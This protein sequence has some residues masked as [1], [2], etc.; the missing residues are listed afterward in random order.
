MPSHQRTTRAAQL[1]AARKGA[2]HCA[3]PGAAKGQHE[4]AAAVAVACPVGLHAQPPCARLTTA[5]A[6]WQ[7]AR[8]SPRPRDRRGNPPGRR[9]AFAPQRAPTSESR[10][11][12]KQQAWAARPASTPVP[13]GMAT[14]R[15]AALAAELTS[16]GASAWRAFFAK[17]R[18]TPGPPWVLEAWEQA[19]AAAAATLSVGDNMAA[20]V[21]LVAL[22]TAAA[23]SAAHAAAAAAAVACD[24][25]ANSTCSSSSS[26]ALRFCP[27]FP[28]P[29]VPLPCAFPPSLHSLSQQLPGSCC[30]TSL[31]AGRAVAL[32]PLALPTQNNDGACSADAGPCRSG[33]GASRSRSTSERRLA[34]LA[35]LPV[36]LGVGMIDRACLAAA[37]SRGVCSTLARRSSRPCGCCVAGSSAPSMGRSGARSCC[38]PPPAAAA[39]RTGSWPALRSRTAAPPASPQAEGTSLAAP[40]PC[41]GDF[42]QVVQKAALDQAQRGASFL[43]DAQHRIAFFE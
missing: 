17:G 37:C 18:T 21:V 15:V 40:L 9:A 11:R 7:A 2:P 42:L 16:C 32:T 31:P 38:R 4:V 25:T 35:L 28:A 24:L 36:V 12:R 23:A 20:S 29:A 14:L 1:L 33:G 22:A 10:V 8:P 3:L 19:A 41:T 30:R 26:N 43:I 5:H 27:P 6:Q 13:G 39:A 34:L